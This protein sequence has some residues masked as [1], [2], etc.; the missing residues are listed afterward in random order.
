MKTSRRI[1]LSFLVALVCVSYQ[2]VSHATTVE[3]EIANAL[4]ACSSLD[5]FTTWISDLSGATE[6]SV[7]GKP[8]SILTRYAY[9]AGCQTAEQYLR[10]QFYAM[11]LVVGPEAS[12]GWSENLI[13][14][15][16]GILSPNEVV[17][18]CAHYDSASGDPYNRAPGAD[19]NAS[20]TA[21]V[22][23]A[24]SIL[25]NFRFERSVEFCLFTAEELG[26][27]GS[28]QYAAECQDAGKEIVAAI[29]MDM[30]IHPTD[31]RQPSLPLDADILTDSPSQ[32][33]AGLLRS[34]IVRYTPVVAEVHLDTTPASDHAP[35]WDI[36]AHAVAV[37]GN[38]PGEA[39]GG[40]TTVYHTTDDLIS[41]EYVDLPFG[42][43]IARGVAAAAMTLADWEPSWSLPFGVTTYAEADGIARSYTGDQRAAASATGERAPGGA[44]SECRAENLVLSGSARAWA[45]GRH[46]AVCHS[47]S[48]QTFIPRSTTLPD[49]EEVVVELKLQGSGEWA[50]EGKLGG[51]YANCC[52]EVW[53]RTTESLRV[54]E[55]T[56]SLSVGGA[57][58]KGDF[59]EEAFTLQSTSL[60]R[61][62]VLHPWSSVITFPAKLGQ[63]VT[64]CARLSQMAYAGETGEAECAW[65]EPLQLSLSSS[66]PD[67]ELQVVGF[68]EAPQVSQISADGARLTLTWQPFSQGQYTVERSDDLVSWTPIATTPFTTWRTENWVSRLGFFRVSSE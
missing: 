10:E 21:A 62:A 32:K 51:L 37:S 12:T 33:L 30:I 13:A 49:G 17:I 11:G 39:Q 5:Q 20:G 34:S 57:E 65:T 3:P 29:N 35:F 46:E 7:H 41:Q 36:G 44:V 60:R 38:T 66:A 43:S 48:F 9:A 42:L 15:L 53:A 64:L 47:S 31:D 6:P 58:I 4:E 19:D 18:I 23:T 56:V 40:A 54:F 45:A 68:A 16:P 67:V 52:V 25:R 1:A 2:V 63:P 22:L 26:L 55:G 27:L 14:R 50:I 28:R 61:E 59:L 8:I 24:A